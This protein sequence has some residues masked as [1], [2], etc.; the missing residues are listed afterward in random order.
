MHT[1]LKVISI[2]GNVDK[3]NTFRDKKLNGRVLL[4]GVVRWHFIVSACLGV[5]TILRRVIIIWGRSESP[6]RVR[7][8]SHV[9]DKTKASKLRI[10]FFKI[11][12]WYNWF[13]VRFLYFPIGSGLWSFLNI[14]FWD[15][16]RSTRTV[17]VVVFRFLLFNRKF[18]RWKY[19]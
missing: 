4:C 3:F 12:V 9:T 2:Y 18:W 7:N 14:T 5:W 6:K 1:C 8:V 13:S 19:C 15:G 10:I 11:P 16:I 17:Y